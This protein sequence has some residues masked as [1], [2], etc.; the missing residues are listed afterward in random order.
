M[1]RTNIFMPLRRAAAASGPNAKEVLL[2]RCRAFAA[3]SPELLQLL[4]VFGPLADLEML[5]EVTTA[6]VCFDLERERFRVAISPEFLER[7]LCD[8]ADLT[9]VLAHEVLHIVRGEATVEADPIAAWARN[10]AADAINNAFLMGPSY[11]CIFDALSGVNGRRI[12]DTAAQALLVPLEAAGA[13]VRE[14]CGVAEGADASTIRRALFDQAAPAEPGRIAFDSAAWAR[15]HAELEERGRRGLIELDEAFAMVRPLLDQL[16]D[17]HIEAD[18]GQAVRPM[19]PGE[20]AARARLLARVRAHCRQATARSG[21]VAPDDHSGP[22]A[23]RRVTL[24]RAARLCGQLQ[25]FVT[26]S[27]RGQP[28]PSPLGARLVPNDAGSAIGAR[29][30]VLY[31]SGITSTPF[32]S[33]A[34]EGGEQPGVLTLYLDVSGSMEDSLPKILAALVRRRPAWL[35]L[36][37]FSFSSAVAPLAMTA[38]REGLIETGD[39]TNF[40]AVVEHLVDRRVRRA[41]IITDGEGFLR[42]RQ[43]DELRQHA[44]SLALVFPGAIIRTPFDDVV[45]PAHRWTMGFPAWFDQ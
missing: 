9:F 37:I 22:M 4:S 10:L 36:P 3:R 41:A 43:R 33:R 45:N 13:F 29:S 15:A 24:D 23:T 44:P 21:R 31:A 2:E 32:S 35:S 17:A 25:R 40:G 7:E 30:T 38:L 12:P 26:D 8:D 42:P 27:V 14:R 39:S 1:T 5:P 20:R 18:A 19:S 6:G 28:S 11:G 16:P 34:P